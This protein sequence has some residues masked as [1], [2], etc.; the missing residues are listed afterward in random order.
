MRASKILFSTLMAAGLAGGAT[1][2][3]AVDIEVN[4]A[5]P[6]DRVEVVPA[7]RPGYTWEKGH[8][9]YDN[10]RYTWNDG[11]WMEDHPGHRYE[12]GRWE[13]RGE[14]WQFHAGHWDDD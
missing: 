13:H 8:W 11:R 5:P 10:N 4:V 14:H 2:S 3:Q 1:A 12:Q 7:P 6:P 9:R